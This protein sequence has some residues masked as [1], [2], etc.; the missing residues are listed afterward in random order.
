MQRRSV[1]LPPPEGPMMASTS[2]AF[3]VSEIS[4]RTSLSPNAFLPLVRLTTALLS[5]K[6]LLVVVIIETLLDTVQDE[7]NEQAEHPVDESRDGVGNHGH[8][9]GGQA[10]AAE[11]ISMMPSTKASDVSF[12][13]VMTSLP[14]AGRIRLMTW[15]STIFMKVWAL[16]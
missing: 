2:P 16:V 15:G 11:N 6:R 10:F 1:D 5:M 9:A 3:T 4:F 8:L 7:F 14:M 12:T 13:S